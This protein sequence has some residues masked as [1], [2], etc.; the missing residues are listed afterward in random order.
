[1][2]SSLDLS[3]ALADR[4][5]IERE[6]DSGN[7]EARYRLGYTLLNSGRARDAR[8]VL[9]AAVVRDPLY[10]IARAY[11]GWSEVVSGDFEAGLEDERRSFRLDPTNVSTVAGKPARARGLETIQSRS[12]R[13]RRSR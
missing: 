10:A 9:Q 2:P 5:R 12:A 11:L 1:V 13:V 3:A 4:Y 8:P 6:L 7:V